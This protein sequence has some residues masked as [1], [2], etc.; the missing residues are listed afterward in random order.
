MNENEI[1]KLSEKVSKGKP[2]N[3]FL[4]VA[5]FISV[6]TGLISMFLPFGKI[7]Y[8]HPETFS[9]LNL[10]QYGVN[11]L[12]LLLSIV[13]GIGAN[14]GFL[15]VINI[16]NKNK[17]KKA[18]IL[19]IVCSLFCFIALIICASVAESI[20]WDVEYYCQMRVDKSIAYYTSYVC[21]F[22]PLVLNSVSA[23]IV[24]LIN[25]GKITVEKMFNK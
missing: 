1:T 21:I 11:N 22:I 24:T 20:L 4:R 12:L 16:L 18:I 10:S 17:A 8:Y 9:V 23:I 19:N 13:V 7:M 25:S 3:I 5:T 6:L 2:L 15:S 14:L